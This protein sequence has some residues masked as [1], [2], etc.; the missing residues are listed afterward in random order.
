MK[1][2][3]FSGIFPENIEL[4]SLN[5]F[6]DSKSFYEEHKQQLKDG[7]T[8]P[9]RQIVLDLSETV[10]Q[11]EP[12]ADLNPVYAVS[13]IRRDTRRTKSKMLYRENLWLMLR[14][15]KFAYP[16]APCFWFE[17]APGMYLYGL[18]M[19]SPKQGILDYVRE[20]II[21]EPN[22]WL[23]AVENLEKNSEL[24]YQTDEFYKKDK[25]PNCP[26][27]L[28]KFVNAKYYEFTHSDNKMERLQNISIIDELQGAIKA[29]EDV[30]KFFI[31]AYDKA[32]N[33]GEIRPDDYRR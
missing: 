31:E 4:L 7:I 33:E 27:I 9:M 25:I 20:K 19:W 11:I 12:L 2:Y 24:R 8:I 14:R 28:K 17:F 18:G 6:N 13:R 22:R 5:R 15:N 1:E 16:F 3:N 21:N 32:Y 26:D 10:S 23:T 30:Y 29:S